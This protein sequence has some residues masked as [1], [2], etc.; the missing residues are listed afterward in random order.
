MNAPHALKVCDLNL[1]QH[2]YTSEIIRSSLSIADVVKLNEEEL[3]IVG[4]TLD[5][6]VLESSTDERIAKLMSDFD[7]KLLALTRGKDGTVLYTASDKVVGESV[8]FPKHP[9]ADDVGAGDACCAA[10]TVGFLLEK[11][12]PEIVNL[13]NRVGAYVA[14]Q[15][16]ATP[17]LPKEILSLF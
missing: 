13:A 12:L 4:N 7:L 16:G 10:I 6:E 17:V 3:I 8:E 2:Y 14:S 5:E 11:P 15:P 1:R 9:H